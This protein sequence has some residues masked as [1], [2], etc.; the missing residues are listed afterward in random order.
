LKIYNKL[1]SSKIEAYL[2]VDSRDTIGA[3]VDRS[4]NRRSSVKP[5]KSL[6]VDIPR[7]PK[8]EL[9]FFFVLDELPNEEF[10]G[11]KIIAGTRYGPTHHVEIYKKLIGGEQKYIASIHYDFKEHDKEDIK[12]LLTHIDPEVHHPEN[13][14]GFG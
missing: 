13:G 11:I 8:H 2:K 4:R 9:K 5:G 7:F 10:V 3:G 14:D 6:E 1:T 12:E